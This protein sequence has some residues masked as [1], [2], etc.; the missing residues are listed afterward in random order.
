MATLTVSTLKNSAGS[1]TIPVA[2]LRNR[3]IQHYQSTYTGGEWNPNNS[4][5]WIPGG[6][7]DFTPRRADSRIRFMYR[8]PYA[9]VAASHVISHW[10]FYVNG[11]VYFWHN[12]SGTH[13]E[14]GNT[15][16]WDFPSWG[17]TNGRIG[18][19]HRSYA[20][21][22]HEVR[23]NT[24]YYWDG[25]GRSAQNC[26]SQIMIEEYVG[27]QD[28]QFFTSSTTELFKAR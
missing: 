19:Q 14:D 11:Q 23:I 10:K 28:D 13:I 24:T 21:D 15:L 7:V 3:T 22:N 25:G 26:Y 8:I 9:W 18:Y 6:F 5:N 12:M 1:V 20:D 17:T 2:D 4:Y 27:G 16:V